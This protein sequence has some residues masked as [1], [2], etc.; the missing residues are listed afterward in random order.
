MP[1]LLL[2][3]A[4][5]LQSWGTT[6]RFDRRE[7]D[8]EPSKSGVL[9]LVCAALGRDR[10]M[11]L[12]DLAALRLGVR[13][14]RPGVLRYDYQTA[15]NVIAADQS[16]RHPTTISR[17]F[18]L[19]DAIFV[20]GLEG[21]DRALL[22]TIHAA[23]RNPVWP[24]AL[25][26]KSYLPSPGPYLKD[27]LQELSLEEALGTYTARGRRERDTTASEQRHCRLVLE[28]RETT[29]GALRMDQPLAPFAERRFGARI[30]KVRVCDVPEPTDA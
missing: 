28:N 16:K 3:L 12:D 5:P 18:Y 1:T 20:A 30:V 11:P 14:D 6:S 15:S 17:R 2:L 21:E 8:Q 25:G 29:E 22:H 9:G 10:T 4:G 19:S 27:G 13:V 23:L 26:R 7:T 24:L